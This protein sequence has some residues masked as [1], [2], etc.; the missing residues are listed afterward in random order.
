MEIVGGED[1]PSF[2]ITDRVRPL[3]RSNDVPDGAVG[4]PWR[5]GSDGY[6]SLDRGARGISRPKPDRNPHKATIPLPQIL[7]P[8]RERRLKAVHSHGRWFGQRQPE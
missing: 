8:P 7:L 1:F 3:N 5:R 4:N 6:G 2:R